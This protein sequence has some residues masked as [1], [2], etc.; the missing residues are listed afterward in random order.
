MLTWIKW[1]VLSVIAI[2]ALGIGAIY[3]SLYLSLPTLDGNASTEHIHTNTLLS[4]DEMG[5]AIITAQISAT[6]PT[7]W[8]LPM[9]K[10]GFFKWIYNAELHR[11]NCLNG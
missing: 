3:L 8:A 7:R 4:R 5:H 1:L 2:I 10:T 11:V 6:L 9:G